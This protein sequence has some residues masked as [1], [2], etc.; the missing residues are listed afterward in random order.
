[1]PLALKN[2]TEKR[3]KIKPKNLLHAFLLKTFL[4]QDKKHDF[5][6]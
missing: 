4:K 3:P 6:V 2:M 5:S 1:M